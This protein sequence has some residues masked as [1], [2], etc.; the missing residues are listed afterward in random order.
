[1]R[2]RVGRFRGSVSDRSG[3]MFAGERPTGSSGPGSGRGQPL[4]SPEP[5]RPHCEW[6]PQ[7][8]D[9]PDKIQATQISLDFR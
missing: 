8:L 9:L 2:G 6:E 1:M 7:P 5:A 4:P 3:H